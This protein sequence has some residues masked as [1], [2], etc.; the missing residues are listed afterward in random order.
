MK[1][2]YTMLNG[3]NITVDENARDEFTQLDEQ[4]LK[5]MVK[6]NFKKSKTT[7]NIKKK[8]VASI[9]GLVVLGGAPLM[10]NYYMSGTI[11]SGLNITSNIMH[12]KTVVGQS[13][14]DN[15]I[16]ITLNDI[17]FDTDEI[18]LSY[19]SEIDDILPW[20]NPEIYINGE[21]VDVI[22][23]DNTTSYIGKNQYHTIQYCEVD[24]SNTE[25]DIDI[26]VVLNS[27]SGE[28]L[29]FFNV[30]RSINIAD[31]TGQWVFD[32]TASTNALRADTFEVDLDYIVELDNEWKIRL[33]SFKSNAVSTK[34]YW[35]I[36]EGDMH[37]DYF[38]HF[39]GYD[40]FGN[41][42]IQDTM[43]ANTEKGDTTF[44]TVV[45]NEY[46]YG[47]V[48]GVSSITLSAGIM[49]LNADENIEFIPLGSEFTIEIE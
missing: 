49:Q 39:E 42:I 16:T 12:Y 3:C 7:S 4:R 11:E 1:N 2:I 26:K 43:L 20:F 33:D 46:I 31:I 44:Q 15:D 32:F 25:G 48:D 22:S 41:Q 27:N 14:T 28:K 37:I 18:I 30:S 24:L 45:N 10:A 6:G 9:L 8:M 35:S 40:N 23:S 21:Q 36:V 38:I 47:L 5:N 17:A 13:Y 19:V 29:S 34:I